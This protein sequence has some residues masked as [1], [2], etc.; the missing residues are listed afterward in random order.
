MLLATLALLCV[1]QAPRRVL[2]YTVSA[3]FEHDVVKR[4]QPELPSLVERTLVDYAKRRGW[5][6]VVLSRDARDFTAQNLARFDLVFFYTTGELPFSA[7]N[8]RALLDFVKQGRGFAGA[9]MRHGH[10]LRAGRVRPR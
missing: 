8:K 5:F 7:E 9:H 1:A 4:E 3:G 6:E 10:V 2:V